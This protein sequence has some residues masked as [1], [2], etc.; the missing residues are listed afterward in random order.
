MKNKLYLIVLVCLIGVEALF[1]Q[2]TVPGKVT[3]SWIG[4]TWG[5]DI[6]ERHAMNWIN[7]FAVDKDGTVFCSSY[8]EEG[9]KEFGIYKDGK[10]LGRLENGHGSA[11]GG[12]IAVN[13]NAVWVSVH[14]KAIRKYSKL[15]KAP[16]GLEFTVGRQVN[17]LAA[18]GEKLFVATDGKDE[19]GVYDT[20]GKLHSSFSAH[21]PGKL[22]ADKRG[23]VWMIEWPFSNKLYC[24]NPSGA[25]IKEI[26]LGQNVKA[27]AIGYSEAK[28]LL[29][30]ANYDIN[31]QQVF[32]Y[33]NLATNPVRKRTLGVKGGIYSGTPGLIKPLKL[34]HP[35][36]VGMDDQGIIYVDG[37][38][39]Y[40]DYHAD[41]MNRSDGFGSHLKAFD[42]SDKLKWE[43]I[44]TSFVDMAAIDPRSDGSTAYSKH[45]RF[46]LDLSKTVA[47]TEWTY[48]AFTVD[49]KN[50]PEDLRWN[51][52]GHQ[53]TVWIRYINDK[54]M[55]YV[56]DMYCTG[57]RIYRFEGEIAV[58]AG[59]VGRDKI[60][61]DKNGN[62]KEEKE[63]TESHTHHP[64][65]SWAL[66]P[67]EN[68]NIWSA[69]QE[70]P[71]YFWKLNG[72]NQYGNP[73]YKLSDV[74][75][76]ARP[77]E[78]RSV[79]RV[80]YDN[81]NDRMYIGGWKKGTKYADEWWGIIGDQ[82]IAYDGWLKGN[83]NKKY[84]LDLKYDINSK[85]PL[86]E[87][88]FAYAGDYLFVVG[89]RTRAR[90]L[91]YNNLDGSFKGEIL[92]GEEIGGVDK[93]GWID[94]R[95]G[96]D[97]YLRSTGEY[98]ILVE[99]DYMGKVIMYRWKP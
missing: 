96:V 31:S 80:R 12:A 90:T 79:Q 53:S 89:S 35:Y 9:G 6:G 65:D 42:Q 74:Q 25:K 68:G 62:G 43:I 38:G 22:A 81:K 50:Y 84:A 4:N 58:P 46:D 26:N 77:E 39:L 72:L 24:Y 32:V 21:H 3:T 69:K 23:N 45:E 55:L 59:W 14:Q 75:T 98:L 86:G 19:I 82:I 52:K 27:A 99:E 83:K 48:K 20:E 29:V 51:N 87:V 16:T 85:I 28:D 7:T 33:G 57:L 94:V 15:T 36:N 66:W 30:I 41:G 1:A 88:S 13:G 67:D 5:G 10:D 76:F 11:D 61:I 8:W 2:S 49:K 97:A 93:T 60:W 73:H 56:G 64:P 40:P 17:G 91:V 70:G 47:G 37:F 92:P 78:F 95:D 44:C 54:K 18:Q 34:N 71:I 63:E